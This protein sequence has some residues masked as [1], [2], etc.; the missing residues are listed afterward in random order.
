M[1]DIEID[2]LLKSYPRLRPPLSDEWL[3]HYDQVYK[4][5]RKGETLIYRI[6]QFLES[7]MHYQVQSSSPGLRLLEIGSGTLNHLAYEKE[8]AVYDVVEPF[9]DLYQNLPEIEQVNTFYD[10]ICEIQRE[11]YYNQI[12]SIASLEHILDLPKVLA[13]AGLL[14][15][16]GG[17][18]NAGIPS[19]GGFLW[20]FSWRV[21]V[22]VACRLKFGLSYADLMRHEHVSNAD[23]I[24]MLLKYFFRNCEVSRFPTPFHHLSL[25]SCIK[26]TDPDIDRC[27]VFA[28]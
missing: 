27:T 20:G 2:Q 5:S 3:S 28:D 18:F 25:Y 17:Q 1:K 11:K 6:T 12:I 9:E 21:S 23:E 26:A 16:P 22:G 8:A 7:W 13:R 24:I 15:A 10:D 14:L 4:S 19:E